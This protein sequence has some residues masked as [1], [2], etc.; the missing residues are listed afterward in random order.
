MYMMCEDADG[1]KKHD[2]VRGGRG[3]CENVRGRLY[4]EVFI[5]FKVTASTEVNQ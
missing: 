1:D 4:I 2:D 3:I 5:L